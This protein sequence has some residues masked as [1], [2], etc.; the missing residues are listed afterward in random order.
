M[1]K[2]AYVQHEPARALRHTASSESAST[3]RQRARNNAF[4]LRAPT[5]GLLVVAFGVCSVDFWRAE[6]AGAHVARVQPVF[7]ISHLLKKTI[8]KNH[9]LIVKN[10]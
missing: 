7:G 1:V 10:S 9:I 3:G 6:F 5:V 8:K 4:C 2:I